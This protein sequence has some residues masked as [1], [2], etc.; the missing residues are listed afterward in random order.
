[1]RGLRFASIVVAASALAVLGTVRVAEA[2]IAASANPNFG[3]H[4]VGVTAPV[5][6]VNL[7]SDVSGA[8]GDV[9]FT[10]TESCA[11][12]A[13]SPTSGTIPRSNAAMPILPLTITFT[14][15]LTRGP[16]PQCVV[17]VTPTG[18]TP[19]P[20]AITFT[21]DG[22]A[23]AALFQEPAG[24][25]I[26][27]G[28]VRWNGAATSTRL[29]TMTNIGNESIATT[30]IQDSLF[31]PATHYTTTAN[32]MDFPVAPTADGT[33]EVV[34]A[35]SAAG[36]LTAT[37]TFRID[38]D[39]T[40]ESATVD[41][42]GVGTQSILTFS[43]A[44][45]LVFPTI[46]SIAAGANSEATMTLGNLSA[47]GATDT[48][49]ITSMTIGGTNAGDFSFR[50]HGC[51]GLTCNP[52][53]NTNPQIGINATDPYVIRCTPTGFGTR[54][55]VLTVVSDDATSGN[56]TTSKTYNLSCP[57]PQPVLTVSPATMPSFGNVRVGEIGGPQILTIS[58]PGAV[59]TLTYTVS[60]GSAEFPLSC[61]GGG[62][63]CLTGSI[64]GNGTPVQIEVSFSP[65]TTGTRNTNLL[66]TT[67]DPDL[68]D[69]MRTYPV[70]GVGVISTLGPT[71]DIGFGNVDIA[72]VNGSPQNLVLNNTGGASLNVSRLQIAGDAGNNFRFSFTNCPSGQDCN[73][74][75]PALSIAAGGNATITLRCDPTTT[76]SKTGTLVITSDDPLSPRSVNLTCNGT[77]P[78][79]VVAPTTLAD[80]GNQ[81]RGQLSAVV[82]TF[83]ISNPTGATAAPVTYT[84]SESSPH[85]AITC[86]AP[87]CSGTINPG[88]TPV[89]V[90]VT[91]TPTAIGPL[92]A[93]I[94]VTSNDVAEPTI[95][96]GV[97][98]V[99]VE[100]VIQ[101]D[102]PSTLN[103][104]ATNVGATSATQPITV[105]NTGTQNLL[106]TAVNNTN[107]ADF[108]VTG[109]PVTVTV[110][111]STSAT[112]NVAC[113]P[114]TQGARTAN[115]TLLNDSANATSVVVTANCQ[116]NR[117]NVAVT[118]ATPITYQA[119][120]NLIDFGGVILG[121]MRSTT[122]TLSNNGNVPATVS[123]MTFAPAAQ[124]FTTTV[125][126]PLTVPAGGT[127]TFG[128]TF[129]PTVN[130]QGTA[131]LSLDS[132][133]N[134]PTLNVTGDG[135]NTGL[136]IN[137]GPT[138]TL[139]DVLFNA[140]F[141][142][143]VRIQNNG[144]APAPLTQVTLLN[145]N[146]RFTLTG[147]PGTLPTL[148]AFGTPN[149]HLNVTLTATPD[150]N[151]LATYMATL[152]V[153]TSLPA[154][155]DMEAS[156]FTYSSIG[157]GL[158]ITP[159]TTIDF[160]A[161]DVDTAGGMVI[162][163]TVTNDG[164]V[165]AALSIT[166]VTAPPGGSPFTVMA[167][168]TP[169]SVLSMAGMNTRTMMITYDPS[170]E[171]AAAN[172]ETATVTINN[173]GFFA[174]DM[175]G[176]AAQ[177]IM[178]SGRG[179]DRHID[180]RGDGDQPTLDFGGV[181]RDPKPDDPRATK[182][183]RVCNTGEA[184][185]NVTMVT[186]PDAPFAVVG[187]TS[188]SIP[189][190]T[191]ET[192]QNVTV[193]F[194]PTADITGEAMS[195]LTVM[196]NDNSTQMTPMVVVTLRGHTM[197]RP[198]MVTPTA[199]PARARIAVGVPVRLSEILAPGGG[200]V[201]MNPDADEDFDI[202]LEIVDSTGATSVV[203]SPPATIAR[204]ATVTYDLV[205][206]ART[207]GPFTVTANVFLDDD[208]EVHQVTTIELEA[209]QVEVTGGVGCSAG[210]SGAGW[211]VLALAALGLTRRRTRGAAAGLVIAVAIAGA[212]T[213]ARAQVSREIEVG[214]FHV[215]PASETAMFTVESPRIA[216]KG[217]WAIGL[218]VN[219]AVSPLGV[220]DG[221]M[222]YSLVK[223]RTQLELGFGY[224][225]LDRLEV[226]AR[227]PVIQQ[228]GEDPQIFGLKPAEGTAIGDAAVSAKLGLL[229]KPKFGLALVVEGTIPTG[230][231]GQFA[232]GRTFG[233]SG[234][235]ALGVEPNKRI[236]FALNAGFLGRGKAEFSTLAQG[237]SAVY[238][239][240]ISFRALE[241]LWIIA[242]GFGEVG[243]AGGNT[244]SSRT[245][246]AQG[247]LRYR[248][249]RS[250]AVAAGGGAGI[251]KGVGAPDA[252]GFFMLVVSPKAR[253]DVELH[254][255]IP[256]P[257]KDMGDDDS[258]GVVNA[259]DGCKLDAEDKDDYEDAD[260]CPEADNDGDGVLDA[261]D[262]CSTQPEDKDGFEDGDGCVDV[263]ND[264]DGVPDID[265]KCAA[266]P[267]DKD[268]FEDGD[269]C[270]EPDNDG[271]GIPD[272]L[273]QCAMEAE[274]ING[275]ADEDG[276]PDKGD[277]VVMV[278]PDRIE[279]LEPVVFQ[280]TTA[281]LNKNAGKT[282]SQIGAT[283]RADRK[284]KKVRITVHVHPRNAGD[285]DLSDRRAKEIRDWLVNWGVE[286]ER[287]DAKGIGSKRPLVPKN[288]RGAEEI[289]DRVEFIIFERQ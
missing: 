44:G 43:P 39:L 142:Q 284:I 243:L 57:R 216:A 235:L 256:P 148:T 273:D 150:P 118:S 182:Q 91:F 100:P 236:A 200:I 48:L 263:D 117:G 60:S 20:T 149:D 85:F 147:V 18:G 167:F 272:V 197:P 237:N 54:T 268:G 128:I 281:K 89:T 267:E 132:D 36:T 143:V 277:S 215:T 82:R 72:L 95:L 4:H 275:N 53:T 114:D 174:N 109:P 129:A 123:A 280:G 230:K 246:E 234:R 288:S 10:I 122:V 286:P 224:A 56:A 103:F 8:G 62:S 169:T 102:T 108:N 239:A 61:P 252:R 180:V 3:P 165:G 231:D 206:V 98:G 124:G 32:F 71:A 210:G 214:S 192:C 66:I 185:L 282:L 116:A 5:A 24:Q 22:E 19:M 283:L 30:N 208:D 260:G 90:T 70:T 110:A 257:P 34:F 135:Q 78:N 130:T 155:D 47:S 232:G 240:G 269:G 81:R 204:G 137:P 238:G 278:M 156:T 97:S 170:T 25:P 191:S 80:F 159:G 279:T 63:A 241:K 223:A 248:L 55:A 140:T 219:H 76:G 106:I 21:V 2:D 212:A 13:V 211:L 27:F 221:P 161:V 119:G 187:S 83:T 193:E 37:G 178:L 17:T 276:C 220:I 33:Y 233:G 1:M 227:L 162:P 244:S 186:P 141:A 42:T 145:A 199:L 179:I 265:D 67:N 68:S 84:A 258:D 173:G 247:G 175:R 251:M 183:L 52:P 134:D 74:P 205:F 158:V 35:P 51:T 120:P 28:N 133:W 115:I 40:G 194:R 188:F 262:K 154:P 99:G 69:M 41:V 31:A 196:N 160:G 77:T 254:P 38:N 287:L 207:P 253:P 105:T 12:V 59:S 101:L 146:G 184:A 127:A 46:T 198:V 157:P 217:A 93:N 181:Y 86:S 15:P 45:T 176:A 270:E 229:D 255:Y 50:D 172:P 222:S 29:I 126:L 131:V 250:I 209:V 88:A 201:A 139:P 168:P 166:S 96:V 164:D 177:T 153:R 202:R 171:R 195:D 189:G 152:D 16:I 190:S 121:Q 75:S 144:Q 125:T 163:V 58:N 64:P 65:V 245:F 6:T 9:P 111:P 266:E 151:N 92:T 289:N 23:T 104:P 274:T 271:D 261:D 112:F 259:D 226:G 242:E 138:F 11:A 228:S 285:Q 73:P 94:S 264:A 213:T 7:T 87:G 107:A 203:G 113:A 26:N 79:V 218:S 49:N 225:V 249:G 136:S 14:A